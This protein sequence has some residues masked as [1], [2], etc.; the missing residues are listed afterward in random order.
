MENMSVRIDGDGTVPGAQADR[1]GCCLPANRLGL[2]LL[3][4][5]GKENFTHV[6]LGPR[7]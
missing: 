5:P 1:T 3:L 6:G 7:C 2:A 4:D